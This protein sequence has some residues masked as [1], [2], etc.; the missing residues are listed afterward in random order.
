MMPYQPC[1]AQSKLPFVALLL[2][3]L[4]LLLGCSLLNQSGNTSVEDAIINFRP[5]RTAKAEAFATDLAVNKT[6]VAI[7]NAT[8]AANQTATAGAISAANP[9]SNDPDETPL[10]DEIPQPTLTTPPP[11]FTATPT[12]LP[13][14]TAKGEA[15]NWQPVVIFSIVGVVTV[16]LVLIMG[17]IRIFAGRGSFFI[18]NTFSIGRSKI[19]AL[20]RSVNR[21]PSILTPKGGLQSD[22]ERHKLANGSN[23]IANYEDALKLQENNLSRLWLKVA[24]YG[25]L[26]VPIDIENEIEATD[27]NITKLKAKLTE[28]KSK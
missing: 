21:K 27:E 25:S 8:F 22:L 17:L 5:T 7:A 10:P 4:G 23:T 19:H 28:L 3:G 20:K 18:T 14:V 2:V 9:Q 1:P 24:Q 12:Q 26:N 11:T 6:A 13:T 15:E 16:V